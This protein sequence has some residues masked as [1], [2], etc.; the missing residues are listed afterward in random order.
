MDKAKLEML[1]IMNNKNLKVAMKKL[2]DTAEKIL[3]VVD[4]QGKLL[5]TVTDGDIRRGLLNGLNFT[6]GIGNVMY[7]EFVSLKIGALGLMKRDKKN[8][9]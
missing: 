2:N 6:D 9:A 4:E 7:K 3:F 1:F 8:N 5:G